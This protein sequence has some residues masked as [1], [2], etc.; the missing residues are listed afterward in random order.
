MSDA[1][2]ITLISV[3]GTGLLGILG[4]L[5]AKINHVG[6]R[7]RDVGKDTTITREQTQNSHK[8]NLRDD[9]DGK[10]KVVEDKLDLV[11]EVVQGLQESDLNQWSAIEK[12]RD[13]RWFK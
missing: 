11:L 7:V 12:L 4:T 8:S 9:I 5:V 3:F 10:H 2:L 1:V 13:R 6:R